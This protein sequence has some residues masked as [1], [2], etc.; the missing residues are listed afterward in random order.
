MQDRWKDA[1]ATGIYIRTWTGCIKLLSFRVL[2]LFLLHVCVSVGVAD[3]LFH[4][5]QNIQVKN[6]EIDCQLCKSIGFLRNPSLDHIGSF[7][8][9]HDDPNKHFWIR[10]ASK[11]RTDDATC[12]LT[13]KIALWSSNCYSCFIATLCRNEA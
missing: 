3:R 11:A 13:W 10:C 4:I 1:S 2:S 8:H 5:I 12:L 6:M 9:R 7:V